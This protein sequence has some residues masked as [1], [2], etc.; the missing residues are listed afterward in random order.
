MTMGKH[1][2]IDPESLPYRSCVGVMVLNPQG[3]VWVGRRKPEGDGEMS[4]GDHLWQMPQ[5][6][7][8]KGEEPLE[9]ARREIFEETGMDSLTL[10]EEAPDWIKLRPAGRAGRRRL[11]RQISRP[12]AEMVRLSL[13]RF[14]KRNPHRSAPRRPP[15]GVRP[16]GVAADVRPAGTDRAVQ[17]QG[18]RPS[19]GGVRA[20]R[21]LNLTDQPAE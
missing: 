3:L 19:G 1:K 13:P 18:L 15:G 10:I 11:E 5:G 6:G 12:D 17:A 21:R 16:V 8:D 7:I 20:S 2:T 4:A 9:A 14:R